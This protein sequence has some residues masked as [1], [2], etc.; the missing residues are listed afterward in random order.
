MWWV[1][2]HVLKPRCT[3]SSLW[4]T[5]TG[6]LFLTTGLYCSRAA[7]LFMSHWVIASPTASLSWNPFTRLVP[8]LLLCW[9]P[10]WLECHLCSINHWLIFCPKQYIRMPHS[11]ILLIIFFTSSHANARIS[12]SSSEGYFF[13]TNEFTLCPCRAV[14]SSFW[15]CLSI[16]KLIAWTGFDWVYLKSNLLCFLLEHPI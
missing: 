5:C 9:C 4:E 10:S 2:L 1:V 14:R 13:F 15:E 7:L 8:F 12:S 16:S 6:Q 3:F 11:P